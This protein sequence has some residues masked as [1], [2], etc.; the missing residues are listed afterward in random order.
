M[1]K[2]LLQRWIEKDRL[3]AQ[4]KQ[5]PSSIGPPREDLFPRR[6]GKPS[7]FP[8]VALFATFLF[9]AT[10]ILYL[11]YNNKVLW[12]VFLISPPVL[13]AAAGIVFYI[14]LIPSS[15]GLSRAKHV[16]P[17]DNPAKLE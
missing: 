7:I 10:A 11:S 9:D 12:R 13:L 6:G 2:W 17:S 14:N 16:D 8:F 5:D 3:I 15:K 1:E 4:F